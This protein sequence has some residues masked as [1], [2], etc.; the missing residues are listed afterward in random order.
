MKTLFEAKIVN[1]GL[2]FGSDHNR[3]RFNQYLKDNPG[4]RVKIQKYENPVSDE[5]RGY[6]F[7]ALIPFLRQISPDSWPAMDDDQIYEVLKK[8]FNYFEAYNPLTKRVERFGQSVMNTSCKN[9]KAM[10]FIERIGQWVEEN[11]N[12]TLPDPEEYKRWRDSAP[13]K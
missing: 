9:L 7:G 2:D 4:K 12:Q 1:G 5:M 6:M 11:Y 13:M 8:N 10:E 3:I